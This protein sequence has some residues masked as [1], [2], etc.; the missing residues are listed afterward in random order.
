MIFQT[1][2]GGIWTRS[3]EGTQY[4]GTETY[5][6]PTKKWNFPEQKS[7]RLFLAP[8]NSSRIGGHVQAITFVKA[9]SSIALYIQK[10]IKITKT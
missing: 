2:N 8:H 1:S 5:W 7:I 9:S 6:N 3:L 10:Y 4:C